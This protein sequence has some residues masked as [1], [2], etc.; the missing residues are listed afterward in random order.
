MALFAHRWSFAFERVAPAGFLDQNLTIDLSGRKVIA[1]ILRFTPVDATGAPVDGVSVAS[2]YGSDR[3]RLAAHPGE[4]ID[5]LTFDGEATDRVADVRVDV[6]EEH[7]VDIGPHAEPELIRRDAS[8]RVLG[9]GGGF[10][11][12][13]LGNPTPHPMLVR[14]VLLVMSA[15]ADPSQ[16]VEVAADVTPDPVLVPP[17]QVLRVDPTP[18]VLDVLPRFQDR[19]FLSLKGFRAAW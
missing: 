2:V 6:A 14:V 12:L 16:G 10:D 5:L 8:G 13:E 1:P 17:Q 15:V 4:N 19:R 9:P 18:E 3:G 11:H 7:R